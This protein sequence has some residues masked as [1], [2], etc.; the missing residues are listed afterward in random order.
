[1]IKFGFKVKTRNGVVLDNL[2][3]AARDRDEAER[4]IRQIYHSCEIIESA[5]LRPTI[6]EDALDLESMIALINRA[7]AAGR[8]E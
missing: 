4:K 8:K 1:M 3:V 5:E 7:G 2:Q 6:R